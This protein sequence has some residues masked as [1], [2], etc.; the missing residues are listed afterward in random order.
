M[1]LPLNFTIGYNCS[2]WLY[3]LLFYLRRSSKPESPTREGPLYHQVEG[4]ME[5]EGQELQKIA[6]L[7]LLTIDIKDLSH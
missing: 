5:R 7:L 4:E 3:I 1:Q 2:K 6:A